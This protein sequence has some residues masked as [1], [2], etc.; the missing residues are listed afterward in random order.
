MNLGGC[1]GTGTSASKSRT[2]RTAKKKAAFIEGLKLGWSVSKACKK[3]DIG[4][5]TVYAWKE[6]DEDFSNEWD[7]AI[8]EGTDR[9]E[10]IAHARAMRTSDTLLIFML[11]ARRPK[12]YREQLAGEKPDDEAP[13]APK[14]IRYDVVDG[15]KDADAD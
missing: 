15:R 5:T 6:A 10:D 9:L 13:P 11:K 3:A 8:E 7:S 4:R 14:Q 1:M 12:K 2:E